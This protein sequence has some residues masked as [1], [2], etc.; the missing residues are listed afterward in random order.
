MKDVIKQARR[1][2][3][4]PKGPQ[5]DYNVLKFD[6]RLCI[7][8]LNICAFQDCLS[9][10]ARSQKVAPSGGVVLSFHAFNGSFNEPRLDF[11]IKC[12]RPLPLYFMGRK[13]YW[14]NEPDSSATQ[15]KKVVSL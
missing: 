15:P 7:S 9:F 1:A 11:G 14:A 6:C 4:R 3:S 5:P 12:P 13:Q 2:Q 10:N 8:K